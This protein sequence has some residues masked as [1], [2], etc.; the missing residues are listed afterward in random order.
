MAESSYKS[1]IGLLVDVCSAGELTVALD[2]PVR[3]DGL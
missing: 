3:H 2:F 1:P